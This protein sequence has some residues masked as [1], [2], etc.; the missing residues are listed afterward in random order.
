MSAK[1]RGAVRGRE[2]RKEC[3]RRE[4]YE[5]GRLANN[6]QMTAKDKDVVSQTTSALG[7]ASHFAPVAHVTARRGWL[8]SLRH[9][10]IASLMV[11]IEIHQVSHS[12][13]QFE[14]MFVAT[15]TPA[16]EPRA[17]YS[18]GFFAALLRHASPGRY[19]FLICHS[20]FSEPVFVAF[21]IKKKR[22]RT[23]HC[24]ALQCTSTES[25]SSARSCFAT[26][27]ILVMVYQPLS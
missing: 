10:S 12:I 11:A 4:K 1:L 24:L 15:S 18:G 9:S 25:P 21:F 7:T 16:T 17:V 20:N 13:C 3:E 8:A 22:C 27:V 2:V 6:S 14:R 26:H 5:P 23:S 19:R